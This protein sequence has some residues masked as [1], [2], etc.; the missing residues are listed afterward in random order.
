VRLLAWK[1]FRKAIAFSM[2][3]GTLS[4]LIH[5][6]SRRSLQIKAPVSVENQTL[7]GKRD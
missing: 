7:S 5:T 4:L 3:E 2:E 1:D 6:D